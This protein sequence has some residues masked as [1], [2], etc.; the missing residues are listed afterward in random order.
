[1]M[2]ITRGAL[3]SI[4]VLVACTCILPV[5]SAKHRS[6]GSIVPPDPTNLDIAP[7]DAPDPEQLAELAIAAEALLDPRNF[8][9]WLLSQKPELGPEEA[10]AA[11][12]ISKPAEYRRAHPHPE[13]GAAEAIAAQ[14]IR[15]P[16]AA[17]P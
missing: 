3:A 14:A 2:K 1:M 15:N 6:E 13:R 17:L 16:H 10:L 8:H 7:E 4:L 11:L 9:D 12:A 5:E